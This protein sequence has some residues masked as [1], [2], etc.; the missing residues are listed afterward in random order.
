MTSS[1]RLGEAGGDGWEDVDSKEQGRFDLA[2]TQI[3]LC[4][5]ISDLVQYIKT[6]SFHES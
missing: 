2:T 3:V 4:S 5:R 6:G 1:T